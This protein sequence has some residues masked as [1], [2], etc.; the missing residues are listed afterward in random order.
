MKHVVKKIM[1][2]SPNVD[3][4]RDVV[5]RALNEALDVEFSEA[6]AT[7]LVHTIVGILSARGGGAS[8]SSSSSN[9]V[10][11]KTLSCD[12]CAEDGDKAEDADENVQENKA[13]QEEVEPE[14]SRRHAIVVQSA[15]FPLMDLD[16]HNVLANVLTYLPYDDLN[17]MAVCNRRL[18]TLRSNPALDQTRSAT[19]IFPEDGG[20]S[21]TRLADAVENH[22][23]H[24]VLSGNRTA[25]RLIGYVENSD[26]S[27]APSSTGDT[28]LPNVTTLVVS[29]AKR[30]INP[31]IEIHSAFYTMGRILPNVQKI[32]LSFARD[33]FVNLPTLQ[34]TFP[35][36][37]SLIAVDS[38]IDI[39]YHGTA[40]RASSTLREM[41]VPGQPLW[42]K[43]QLH[44]GLPP[45]I[46][47]LDIR[48]VKTDGGS[49]GP[50]DA[51]QLFNILRY[52]QSLRWL[53]CDAST[54]VL[55]QLKQAHPTVTIV[56]F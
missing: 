11:T 22:N 53:R 38:Q 43:H 56:N 55:K 31:Y 17:S 42:Y 1:N 47:R 29:H 21:L 26:D 19:L 24:E 18:R 28:A 3:S 30:P 13:D 27:T 15:K 46:E 40:L 10:T 52:C 35:Q 23:L 2:S 9:Q 39:L 36:L 7:I 4:L 45:N 49:G 37:S 51:A 14:H 41:Y 16:D 5:C 34:A 12:I 50:L 8:S 54:S 6:E 33:D 25:L 48:F 32:D 20:N 44:F